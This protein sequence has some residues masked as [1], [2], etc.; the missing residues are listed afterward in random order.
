[1]SLLDI[2]PTFLGFAGPG[3]LPQA[4]DGED[5]AP[6]IY[7]HAER[8]RDAVLF[9][10]D[11]HQAGTALQEASASPT[12]GAAYATRRSKYAAYLDPNGRATPRYELYDLHE[13]P[14]EMRNL[15]E[16]RGG[17]RANAATRTCASA[18]ARSC[19][20]LCTDSGTLSPRLPA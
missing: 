3:R 16:V 15:L 12:V 9:T 20:W 7:G 10:Y 19:R 4:L 8:C 5:L 18:W 14:L 11:D 13:D 17:R 1:M 6:L 2:P